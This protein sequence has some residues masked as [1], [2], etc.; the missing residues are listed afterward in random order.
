MYEGMLMKK[1]ALLL[2]LFVLI[3]PWLAYAQQPAP[4]VV[5]MHTDTSEDKGLKLKVFFTVRDQNGRPISPE[6]ILSAKLQVG[7]RD[8]VSATIGPPQTPI[9]LAIVL[10]ASGS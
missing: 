9:K 3:V 4:D 10:D 6:R 7:D 1:Y 2:L 5:I 8:P